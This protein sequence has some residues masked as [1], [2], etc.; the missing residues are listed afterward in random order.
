MVVLVSVTK[1]LH[2]VPQFIT[3]RNS[4]PLFC[5]RGVAGGG[6]GAGSKPEGGVGNHPPTHSTG[7]DT[8]WRPRTDGKR[9][10]FSCYQPQGKVMFSQASVILSTI[11]LMDTRSLLILVGYSVGTHPTGM[12]SCYRPQQSWAKVMFLQ[13]SVILSTEGVSASVHPGIHPPRA[14]T[15]RSRPP[16]SRHPPPEQ[17]PPLPPGS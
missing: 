17:T 7:T 12:L 2:Y 10:C 8:Q 6:G 5:P 14:D 1:H 9:E 13:V 11:G 4:G 16:P 15:P 3:A